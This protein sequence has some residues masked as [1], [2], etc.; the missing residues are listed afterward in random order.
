MLLK[1]EEEDILVCYFLQFIPNL[2]WPL[3]VFVQQH[4]IP[5]YLPLDVVHR[6][7]GGLPVDA[8]F[9]VQPEA[10]PRVESVYFLRVDLRDI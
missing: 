5:V 8:R 4:P 9:S 6:Y 1:N 7:C 2:P 10:Y 3:A